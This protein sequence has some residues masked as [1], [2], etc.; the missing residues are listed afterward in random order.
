M[1]YHA[2]PVLNQQFLV[3]ETYEFIRELGQGAYGVVWYVYISFHFSSNWLMTF[4]SARDQRVDQQEKQKQ[5]FGKCHTISLNP[6]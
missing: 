4:D 1:P 3:P 6:R 2:F 5:T